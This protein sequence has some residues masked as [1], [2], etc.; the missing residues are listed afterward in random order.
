MTRF[1]SDQIFT[2]IVYKDRTNKTL[3]QFIIDGNASPELW[4]QVAD[5]GWAFNAQTHIE[6]QNPTFWD[7]NKDALKIIHFLQRKGWQCPE[8]HSPPPPPPFG[9]LVKRRFVV[10]IIVK[11]ST[12]IVPANKG[13][14]ITIILKRQENIFKHV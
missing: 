3:N 9:Q 12:P 5:M 6:F 2:N 10:S 7:A 4:G 14:D 11:K 8:R 13:I 1:E